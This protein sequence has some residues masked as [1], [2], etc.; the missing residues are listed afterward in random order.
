LKKAK[1][2]EAAEEAA[3]N[4]DAPAS[5]AKGQSISIMAVLGFGMSRLV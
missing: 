2:E 1:A 5:S 3:A 4:G